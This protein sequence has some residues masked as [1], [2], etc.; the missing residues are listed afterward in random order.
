MKRPLLTLLITLDYQLQNLII[1]LCQKLLFSRQNL[2]NIHKILIWRGG[3]LG[4]NICALPAFASIRQNFPE[5]QIDILTNSRGSQL[6]SLRELM[7]PSI[8]DH[9]FNLFPLTLREKLSL[10]KS[11]QSQQ[12]DLFIEIP[13]NLATLSIE[14]RN[15]MIAKFLGISTAFGWEIASTR[16][17]KKHQATVIQF[18]NEIQRLLNLLSKQHLQ[19]G[20]LQYP[21][22][23]TKKDQTHLKRH[24]REKALLNKEKNIALVVGAKR[25]ANQWPIAYFREVAD[26]LISKGLNILLVGGKA[27]HMLAEQLVYDPKIHNFCGQ[28][29]P[30]ESGILL[31]YCCLTITNDTGPM[32]LSY[33]VGTPVIAIFSARDYARNHQSKAL[34]VFPHGKI[35]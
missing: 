6:V 13:E 27:D 28:F 9:V 2:T 20:P 32:H 1:R 19:V 29:T 16:R 30:L 25:K 23:F 34:R 8:I 22:G 17:F 14:L 33:A 7:A 12:Y 3:S 5:A 35:K 11:L 21:L 31:Q 26:Y 10:F 18:E 24:L 4:D 15:M